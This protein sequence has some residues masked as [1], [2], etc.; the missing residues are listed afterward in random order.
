[1]AVT[2]AYSEFYTSAGVPKLGRPKSNNTAGNPDYVEYT[3]PT[4]QLDDATDTTFL[5]PVRSGKRIVY[6]ILTCADL[7]SGGGGALDMDIILRT[8][9]AAGVTTDTIL[10]NAGTAFNAAHA[11]L[12][13]FCNALVPEDADSVG[14]LILYVNT[15]ASTAASGAIKLFVEVF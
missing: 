9:S 5:I 15:P 3:I 12:I 11:G 6:M 13:I 7:D 2:T 4:T 14:H 8:T 1:M 10:Y